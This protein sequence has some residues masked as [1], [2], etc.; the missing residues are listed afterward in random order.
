MKTA[1][2]GWQAERDGNTFNPSSREAEK[3]ELTEF[4]ASLADLHSKTLSQ[5]MFF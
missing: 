4:Q 5:K 1:I 3:E 2:N